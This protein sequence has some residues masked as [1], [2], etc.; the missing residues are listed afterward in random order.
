MMF[1]QK[2]IPLCPMEYSGADSAS[3]F[4]L[5]R[6]VV[7][8]LLPEVGRNARLLDVGCGNGYWAGQIARRGFQVVGIDPSRTGI[9]LA[10]ATFPGV[11]F[12]ALDAAGDLCERLGE[13]PFDFITSLEVVEHLYCPLD[14]ALACYRALKPG[15]RLIC[16][17]PYH[18][19]MKNLA[20]SAFDGW[21]RHFAPNWD[22]GHIKFWSRRTIGQLLAQ[23]GFQ[24]SQ[25]Q[26]RGAGRIPY[27]WRSMV[28][29]LPR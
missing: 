12:E 17:T 14:W 22:G 2:A 27:F 18:G 25:M 8:S 13:G 7:F 20:L 24:S 26:F 15:G 29:S 21:D 1:D 5:L 9:E 11:R 19:F 3:D 28:I 10:R 16:S 4:K 23:A 6:P